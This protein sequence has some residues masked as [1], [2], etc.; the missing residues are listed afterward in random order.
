MPVP[1]V[2]SAY[3]LF[4]FCSISFEMRLT[5]MFFFIIIVHWTYMVNTQR[6]ITKQQQQNKEK[7]NKENN[8]IQK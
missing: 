8:S 3:S 2:L 1:D 7:L 6:R 5:N 4:V